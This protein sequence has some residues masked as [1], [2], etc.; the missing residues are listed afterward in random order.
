[1]NVVG[2]QLAIA[3]GSLREDVIS[4][5]EQ[6]KL[7]VSDLD[8]TKILFALTDGHKVIGTGGLEFFHDSAL[9]RS[10]SVKKDY[11]GTGLG[12]SITRQLEHVCR[13]KGIKHIYLL[14]E[15]AEDFFNRQG[16]KVIDRASA[17]LSIRNSSQFTTVCAT[18]GVLMHKSI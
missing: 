3:E 14:T 18:T 10:L 17:P 13:E 15:T 11:R 8:D 4:L 1:M 16:Y 2:H 12:K 9:L 6:N 5:L 7:P